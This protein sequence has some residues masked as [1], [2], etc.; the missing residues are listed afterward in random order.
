TYRY[1]G[2]GQLVQTLDNER[3]TRIFYDADGRVVAKLDGEGYLVENRYDALGRLKQVTRYALATA[4]NLRAEG[5][6]EQ[7]RPAATG[8]LNS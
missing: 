8:A 6:L 3:S 4:A 5:T 2:R 1:D 7:L